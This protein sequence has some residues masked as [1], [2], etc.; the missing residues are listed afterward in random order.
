MAKLK[1]GIIGV[2]FVGE[3]HIEALRRLSSIDIEIKA[4]AASSLESSK[5]AAE[6][7]KVPNYYAD[8]QKMLA[9]E[10]L[11]I[12]HN[13]T[14]NYLHFP[15]NKAFMEAG[16]HV[17]SEKPLVLNSREADELLAILESRDI[18]AGVNFNYRHYPLVK[19]MKQKVKN[20][21]GRLFHLRGSYLQDWMLFEDDYSWRVDP[22]QGGK[23][24]AVADIG[25]HFCDLLQYLTDKKIKRLTAKTKIVHPE[26]Q[27]PAA[28]IKTFAQ[29]GEDKKYE[30]VEV[31]TEDYASVL[32]EMEDGTAGNFTV[33]QVDA[34]HKNDLFIEISG[35]KKSL[36]WSQENANQLFIGHRD[37]ANQIL[38]RDPSLLSSEAAERC[39]YPGGHIEGWSEG[40]KNSIKDFYNCIL[41]AGDPADYDFATFADGALEVKITEAILKSSREEKW[42]EV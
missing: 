38:S 28:E 40:L 5:K 41:A 29:A 4:A 15:I 7:L 13:C 34:G 18:Y 25:S 14:P 30:Q 21:L 20:E 33:S 19:E 1:V 24:R 8:Y 42:V 11:D 3:A 31:K 32:F 36:S 9:E 12:I 26:R 10:D 6:K 23:S 39:Y 27:K 16:V 35:S 2:G 22:K 37:Q 17:F